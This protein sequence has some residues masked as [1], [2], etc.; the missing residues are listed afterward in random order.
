MIETVEELEDIL[1]SPSGNVNRVVARLNGDI[2]ILGVA[3][4]MGPTIARMLVRSCLESGIK[5]KITGVSR[6]SD[7]TIRETLERSGIETVECNLLERKNVEKLPDAENVV[8]L[9]GMKFGTT[10]KEPLTWVMNTLVPALVAEKYRYSRIVA[11]STGNVY[12][13]T[14]VAEG[15][16][17]EE[18]PPEPVGEYA[19]SCLGRE[20]IFQYFSERNR[21]PVATIRLNY[22][23]ELRY[24]VLVDIARRVMNGDSIDLRMGYVNVIWQADANRGIIECFSLCSI[25]PA[26]I[27]LTGR[28]IISV[29]K[30]AEEFASIFGKKPVFVN[31]EEE[32]ALLSNPSFFY[33]TFGD[34]EITAEQMITWVGEWIKKGNPTFDKPTHFETKNGRF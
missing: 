29:R 27:N 22:A 24:G 26:I 20:R 15:G 13:L 21:T 31:E 34:S 18:H 5:K 3:G 19:Q 2:V 23:V 9:A 30:T 32:T 17:T 14:K 1:S 8:F 33:E 10:G 28:E 25:P 16:C 11:L 12:P 7:K 4:K 6:F